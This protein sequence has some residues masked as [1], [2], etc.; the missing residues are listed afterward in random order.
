VN[1]MKRITVLIL[2][3]FISL[4]LMISI[5]C[6]ILG[7]SSKSPI[8]SGG[9][10]GGG[11]P[12]LQ[13]KITF[14]FGDYTTR[15]LYMVN[16]NGRNLIPLDRNSGFPNVD[17]YPMWS[18]KPINNKY[19]ILLLEGPAIAIIDEDGNGKQI[20]TDNNDSTLK[21]YPMWSP[22]GNQIAFIEFPQLGNYGNL[23]MIDLAGNKTPLITS[24]DLPGWVP[25]IPMW[26]PKCG[27]QIQQLLTMK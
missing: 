21:G 11:D 14:R 5:G 9:I 1:K 16:E 26:N 4:T 12:G 18:P 6:S 15:F 19:K 13:Y 8:I 3:I 20:L 27:I 17:N 25:N 2:L 24:E 22:D 7:G 23:S 10:G